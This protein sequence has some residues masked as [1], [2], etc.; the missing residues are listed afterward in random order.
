MGIKWFS[1]HTTTRG[2]AWA[3]FSNWLQIPGS[4]SLGVVFA[5][6]RLNKLK[7]IRYSCQLLVS[8]IHMRGDSSKSA[9]TSLLML[10]TTLDKV[11]FALVNVGE[12]EI[13]GKQPH[14]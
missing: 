12:L 14:A 9:A 11:K 5:G 7:A 4:L 2:A 10:Q 13:L 6:I 3:G 8:V 1:F